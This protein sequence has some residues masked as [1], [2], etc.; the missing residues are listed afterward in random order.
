MKVLGVISEYNPF[1]NGHLHHLNES[2]KATGSD[3]VVSVMSGNF[4]QRGE[5]ALLNKWARAKMALESGIDLVIELPVSYVLQSAEFFA[6]GAVKILNSM[7]MIDYICFGSEQGDIEPLQLIARTLIDEPN[8]I[9]SKI[10]SFLNEGYSFPKARE[11]AVTAFFAN[12]DEKI[13]T[14]QILSSPNNIL[15]IEYLKALNKLNSTIKPTTIKRFK[16]GY[17]SQETKD[18]IASATAI[19]TK[20]Q[21][22]NDLENI[23]AYI[24]PC[25]Y[26]IINDEINAGRMPIFTEDFDSA[27]ITLLRRLK[28]KE[29]A[30]YPGVS[31]GLEH[32]I[33]KAAH[34]YGTLTD[35]LDS[36]QTKR[37]ARTRLQRIMYNVLLGITQDMLNTFQHYGGPQYIRVLGFN[38]KGRQLLRVAKKRASIPILVKTASYKQSCNPLLRQMIE[39]DFLAS[40]LYTLNYTNHSQRKGKM[41]FL[42]SPIMNIQK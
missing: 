39:L 37:Y 34:R 25:S 26:D 35:I 42:T 7:N 17:H 10:K 1:H 29:L 15:G 27:I 18:N 24:P 19:R 8:V 41:D 9:S 40:D 22:N 30:G 4:I 3:Y 23:K 21:N 11:L 38:E 5:P 31:E 2:K 13:N 28:S 36:I 12:K 16:T 14:Q 6:Y 20:L 32:R 33:I